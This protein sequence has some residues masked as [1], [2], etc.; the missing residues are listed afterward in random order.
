MKHIALLLMVL[1]AAGA[2]GS[3]LTLEQALL[4]A[5][6][7]AFSLKQA[8]AG[9]LEA[10]Q[11]VRAAQAER[12]PTLSATGAASYINTV[13][14]LRIPIPNMFTLEREMGSKE[15]YQADLRLTMPLYTGGKISSAVDM[16]KANEAYWRALEDADL[17][18]VRYATRAEYFGL[19][20][21]LQLLETARASLKRTTIIR[22]DIGAQYDAGAADSVDIVEAEL[23]F[24]KADYATRQ[25]DIGVRTA[26]IQLLTRLGSESADSL[27]PARVLPSPPETLPPGGNV[28]Q[29]PELDAALAGINRNRA[30]LNKEKAEYF[31]N[32]AVYTGYSYGKPNQNY[33]ANEWNDYVTVGA[34]LTW[35][36]NLGRKT[37]AKRAA[38]GMA[39]EAAQFNHEQLTER[40]TK[41]TR[42]A[43]EQLRLAHE[44]YLRARAEQRLAETSFRLAQD[45]HREG[46]MSSNRLLE[47][48]TTLTQ[49]ESSLATAVADYYIAE[50][51]YLY[52]IGSENLGKGI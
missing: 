43:Y 23:A 7:H 51:G 4:A 22:A 34:N 3:E 42:L 48:E 36:F 29:R 17:N 31:P 27:R 38:A 33:F 46:V 15:R 8:R 13:P 1:M 47:L 20:R 40:V 39:L 32:L 21:S 49:A 24:T 2:S 6:A 9:T 35:S 19:C 12:Y 16:A 11:T 28:T 26:E 52:A 44:Q 41:E 18:A 45:R 14:T 5:E 37:G 30:A 25:A 10:G 50:S